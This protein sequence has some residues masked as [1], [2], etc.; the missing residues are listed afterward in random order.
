MSTFIHIEQNMLL[1][2]I[3]TYTRVLYTIS[4]PEADDKS[5]RLLACMYN[6]LIINLAAAAA[7]GRHLAP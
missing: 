1:F 6:V 3:C 5:N 2:N 4:G 7:G